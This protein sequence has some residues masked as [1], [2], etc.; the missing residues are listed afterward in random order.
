MMNAC[1]Q[2]ATI[3]FWVTLI[4]GLG[5]G[6]MGY[7]GL[8]TGDVGLTMPWTHEFGGCDLGYGISLWFAY[9]HMCLHHMLGS[10]KR[11][12][13]CR[14]T[15]VGPH[16]QAHLVCDFFIFLVSMEWCT[17]CKLQ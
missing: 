6:F 4:Q 10:I 12:L 17:Y 1:L 3:G 9:M 16:T 15:Y 13:D 11:F 7:D 2:N 5:P 8:W 14:V